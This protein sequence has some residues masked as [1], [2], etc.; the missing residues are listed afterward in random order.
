MSIVGDL[1]GSLSGQGAGIAE[2]AVKG[3]GTLMDGLNNLTGT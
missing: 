3:L 2:N 1:A